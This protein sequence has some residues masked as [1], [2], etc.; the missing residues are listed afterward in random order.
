MSQTE[1]WRLSATELAAAIKTRQ[2]SAREAALAGL[3]RLDDV[4]PRLNAV[5]DH[6]PE[7]VLA[8]A[9]AID[10]RLAAGEECGPLAGV[11]VTIKV[12]TDQ[13]GYATT[14]GLRMQKDQIATQD[15]PVVSNLR[16]SGAAPTPPPSHCAGSPPTSCMATPRTRMIRASPPAAPPAAPP[17]RWPRASAIWRMAPISVARCATRP[18]PAACTGCAPASAASPPGMPPV[19]SAPSAPR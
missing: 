10:Q 8:Q 4:N 16:K 19:P 13:T 5:V 1:I 15:S 11:P 6:R 3:A 18:M 14:N 9:D 7:D 2:I 12:N 17:R